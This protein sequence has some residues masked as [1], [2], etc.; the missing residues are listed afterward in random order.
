MGQ[1]TPV[2]VIIPIAKNFWCDDS[3]FISHFFVTSTKT[4]TN[5]LLPKRTTNVYKTSEDPKRKKKRYRDYKILEGCFKIFYQEWCTIE[6][7]RKLCLRLYLFFFRKQ[8][9]KFVNNTC[10]C[11]YRVPYYK[12]TTKIFGYCRNI[13]TQTNTLIHYID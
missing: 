10:N 6:K 5:H 2:S 12:T 8:I 13:Q 11:F 1:I 3:S 7:N 9:H 4:E